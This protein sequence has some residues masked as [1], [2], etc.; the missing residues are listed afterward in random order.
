[1]VTINGY[2]RKKSSDG[3]EFIALDLIDELEFTHNTKTG[4]M[5]VTILRCSL[6]TTYNEQEAAFLVGRTMQGKVVRIPN[7]AYDYIIQLTIGAL[8]LQN[9]LGY[10]LP[11]LEIESALKLGKMAMA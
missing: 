4:K 3:D 6:P 1:M 7:N 11:F 10:Q 2:S 9:I 8:H 5:Y